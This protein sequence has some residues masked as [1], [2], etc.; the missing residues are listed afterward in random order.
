M[1]ECHPSEAECIL[2]DRF[3]FPGQESKKD[4]QEEEEPVERPI[5]SLTQL[6]EML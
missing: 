6:A 4:V 2:N 3:R 1:Y 5:C